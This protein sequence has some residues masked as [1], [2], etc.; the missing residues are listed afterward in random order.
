MAYHIW[1]TIWKYGQAISR[2][3]KKFGP[4]S[5]AAREVWLANQW[6]LYQDRQQTD[7]YHAN[8][9]KI[10]LLAH[11]IFLN[12]CIYIYRHN[13]YIYKYYV[14]ILCISACICFYKLQPVRRH[15]EEKFNTFVCRI[16]MVSEDCAAATQ[17]PCGFPHVLAPQILA[18][19]PIPEMTKLSCTN[20]Q[21]GHL[22]GGP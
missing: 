1:K 14:Y 3:K 12:K 9:H 16:R 17:C 6:I 18:A 19:N 7:L 21:D 11:M 5:P 4:I 20:S 8:A 22:L 13:I 10:Y 15:R 2:W